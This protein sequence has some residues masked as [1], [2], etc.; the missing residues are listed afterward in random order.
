MPS[1]DV[2]NRK[3]HPGVSPLSQEVAI[4]PGGRNGEIPFPT[5]T[6]VRKF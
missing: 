5:A 3:N 4:L 1:L 6:K 2:P